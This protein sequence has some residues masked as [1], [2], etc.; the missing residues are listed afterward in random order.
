MKTEK[1]KSI[2]IGVLTL[3][4]IILT[5]IIYQN[6]SKTVNTA[7]I[8]SL[9]TEII[10]LNIALD[11]SE[12]KTDSLLLLKTISLN[13]EENKIITIKKLNKKQKVDSL[14]SRYKQFD[15]TGLAQIFT[16][17]KTCEIEREGCIERAYIY[18]DVI[19]QKDTS[20]SILKEE[21]KKQNEIDSKRVL[22]I[23]DKDKKL[24][25]AERKLHRKKVVIKVLGTTTA[26]LATTVG[27][28]GLIVK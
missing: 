4:V 22:V 1:I 6:K 17:L 5:T 15:T 11:N 8:D 7:E 18:Q 27:I 28:L 16:D 23:Q 12:A 25:K 10:G 19:A 26:I 14:K 20:I 3:L 2:V 24:A 21:S 13:D 9:K